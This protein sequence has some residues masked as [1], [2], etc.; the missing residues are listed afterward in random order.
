MSEPKTRSTDVDPR[1]F[2]AND[3]PERFRADSM[4]L[5]DILSELTGEPAVMWGSSIV[6]FGSYLP[7]Q[8]G[9]V[10]WPIIGFSPRKADLTVYIMTGLK[11]RPDLM[12]KLGPH[13]TGSSCLYLKSLDKIDFSVLKELM[14]WSIAYMR[15]K[16]PTH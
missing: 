15:D 9:A 7:S 12:E 3:A 13:K 4:A 14:A 5:L 2:I 11:A 10:P 6:G 1:H 8:K 16:Y